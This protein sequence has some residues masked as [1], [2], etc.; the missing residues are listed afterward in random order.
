MGN[1]RKQLKTNYKKERLIKLEEKKIEAIVSMQQERQEKGPDYH[2]LM[3][4]LP[5][6]EELDN[7]EK[8]Q[9]QSKIHALVSEAY[10]RNWEKRNSNTVVRQ[11]E[12]GFR[13]TTSPRQSLTVNRYDVKL[14]LAH[15]FLLPQYKL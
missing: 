9:L 8:L 2:F 5:Y 4:L 1:K 14:I 7:P 6:I 3:S 13:V 15:Q 10:N 12:A 11:H